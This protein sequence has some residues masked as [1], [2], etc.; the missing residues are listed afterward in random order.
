[1]IKSVSSLAVILGTLPA[2]NEKM[3]NMTCARKLIEFL[4]QSVRLKH[5]PYKDNH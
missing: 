1:L 3:L 4:T 2:R 5:N